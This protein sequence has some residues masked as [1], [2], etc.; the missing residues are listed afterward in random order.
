MFCFSLDLFIR[1]FSPELTYPGLSLN[2]MFGIPHFYHYGLQL[3]LNQCIQVFEH[4]MALWILR[5]V[6]E[7]LRWAL[8]MPSEGQADFFIVWTQGLSFRDIQWFFYFFFPVFSLCFGLVEKL[9]DIVAFSLFTLC[10]ILFVANSLSV[11]N[12][13]NSIRCQDVNDTVTR[14]CWAISTDLVSHFVIYS[15]FYFAD[16]FCL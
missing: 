16:I 3:F 8:F 1:K 2:Q 13:E 14:L 6:P 9:E 15:L 10:E 5:K 4:Q 12:G 7:K 11:S